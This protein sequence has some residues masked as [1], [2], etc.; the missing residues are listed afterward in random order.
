MFLA[1]LQPAAR[2]APFSVSLL[3]SMSLRTR[4][5]EYAIVDVAKTNVYKCM[6]GFNFLLKQQTYYL[7]FR[8]LNKGVVNQ[9]SKFL[10][11]AASPKPR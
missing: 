10:C 11:L 4:V 2:A 7:F 9:G 8:V 6:L 5:S 3:P 1:L